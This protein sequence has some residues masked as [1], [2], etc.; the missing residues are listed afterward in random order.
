MTSKVL[1]VLAMPV[2]AKQYLKWQGTSLTLHIIVYHRWGRYSRSHFFHD[3]FRK[4]RTNTDMNL[5]FV[6]GII[7]WHILLS[8]DAVS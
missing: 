4:Y 8:N 3:R 6:G 1:F 5:T 7:N 2:S